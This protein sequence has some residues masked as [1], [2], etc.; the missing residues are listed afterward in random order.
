MY[1]RFSS[2]RA[3][4]SSKIDFLK[5]IS[6][7]IPRPSPWTPAIMGWIGCQPTTVHISCSWSIKCWSQGP[8][9]LGSIYCKQHIFSWTPCKYVSDGSVGDADWVWV[10][11]GC[12]RRRADDLLSDLWNNDW[13][14]GGFL[15]VKRPL[16]ISLYVRPSF[17]AV[18]FRSLSEYSPLGHLCMYT[19]EI[20]VW[21][22]W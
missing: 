10:R 9:S 18:L 21:C 19:H 5:S 7:K 2:L 15:G 17:T 4:H 11:G 12:R 6:T 22:N 16:K 8:D 14:V 3:Y 13:Q 20:N 1:A